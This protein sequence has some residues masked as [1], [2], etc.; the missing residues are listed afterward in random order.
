MDLSPACSSGALV[1]QLCAVLYVFYERSGPSRERRQE[2]FGRPVPPFGEDSVGPVGLVQIGWVALPAV[3]H[4]TSCRRVCGSIG[5][6]KDA[7]LPENMTRIFTTNS[8]SLQSFLPKADGEDYLY[9]GGVVE[10]GRGIHV[11]G[12]ALWVRVVCLCVPCSALER[13]V[14]YV[15]VGG[16]QVGP[17]GVCDAVDAEVRLFVVVFE[18]ELGIHL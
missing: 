11:A 3:L 14:T 6:Y 8:S 17:Y 4:F 2:H 10:G 7:H 13:R 18:F 16:C 1:F 9:C 5:R 15:D 12:T